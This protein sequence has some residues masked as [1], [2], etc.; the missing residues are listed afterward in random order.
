MS[1]K[2]QSPAEKCAEEL[3]PCP[4]CG[5]KEEERDGVKGTTHHAECYFILWE[6]ELS[7]SPLRVMAWN[8]RHL[9]K[10]PADTGSSLEEV[11][12]LLDGNIEIS[13]FLDEGIRARWI[14]SIAPVILSALNQA[15]HQATSK[16]SIAFESY[17]FQ[18]DI[19]VKVTKELD[20]WKQIC[21]NRDETVR[22]Q[23]DEWVKLKTEID[24]LLR[25]KEALQKVARELNEDLIESSGGCSSFFSRAGKNYSSLPESIRGK[26][27]E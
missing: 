17:E 21:R 4:F 20:E 22:K 26:D 1:D 5:A 8:T 18:R 13:R 23:G 10:P 2:P 24:Q 11:E 16:G 3:K 19:L 12:K 7:N 6:T 9:P 15:V 25:D 14:K 27:K